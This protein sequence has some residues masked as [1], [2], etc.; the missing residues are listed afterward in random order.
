MLTGVTGNPVVLFCPNTT[1][2][3]RID[4]VSARGAL[5]PKEKVAVPDCPD[6]LVTLTV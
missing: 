6:A 3:T 1:L 4:K 2:G 5:I